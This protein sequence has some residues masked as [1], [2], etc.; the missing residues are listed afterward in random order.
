[1]LLYKRGR[2]GLM[3]VDDEDSQKLYLV[4]ERSMFF[5]LFDKKIENLESLS[6]DNSSFYPLLKPH[7]I[8]H[9]TPK[10]AIDPQS[11]PIS[12]LKFHLNPTDNRLYGMEFK[13]TFVDDNRLPYKL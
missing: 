4:G 9:L 6:S 2:F 3:Y 5:R 1:M 7:N 8:N 10:L 11:L 13:K 12:I